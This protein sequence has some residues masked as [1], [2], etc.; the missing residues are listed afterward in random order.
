[1]KSKELLELTINNPQFLISN[2]RNRIKLES[3]KKLLLACATI[4]AGSTELSVVNVFRQNN[5][6]PTYLLEKRTGLKYVMNCLKSLEGI[7]F[8]FVQQINHLN[9]AGIFVKIDDHKC[10]HIE[11]LDESNTLNDRTTPIGVMRL[12]VRLLEK[13]G[14]QVLLVIKHS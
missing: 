8:H 10:F 5:K 6:A 2:D 14:C 11:V 13:L 1:M 4:E 7:N 12:K 3:R 9:I